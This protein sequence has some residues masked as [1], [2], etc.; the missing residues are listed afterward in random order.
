M[1]PT[2]AARDLI[3][4]RLPIIFPEGTPNRN[5]CTRELAASTVFTMLY[6]GAVEGSGVLLGPVH[7][8]RMTDQQAADWSDEGRQNYRLNLRK[9]NFKVPGNRWYADN[10]REPIR[11][12]TL[13]EGLIAIGAVIE[14][15]TVSTTAGAPRYS[16]RKGL[17]ALFEPS[18]SGEE[19]RAAV[20]DWQEKHLNK[21]A[22]AR[23]S[24]MRLG[25]A[26]KKGV[27]VHFP[28]GETRTLSP[29]PSSEI[30]RAVV[31]VFAKLFLGKPVVLWLSESSNKVAMQD[32]RM[33]ASIGLDIEAQKNLPDLILVDLHPVHPLIVFVEVVAT[34]GAITERRQEALFALTDKG[35]FERSNVA[36]VTAYADRQTQGFKKTISGLAW[37]SF[38]WFLS[39]PDKVFMLSDGIKQLSELNGIISEHQS[40]R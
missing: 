16:I 21:G 9:R 37:G 33:A 24:L 19:F 40:T 30:S 10:T 34:D 18:L 36:F 20:L 8:Y 38:A 12:E 29:G 22:L 1:L 11:D 5:Y 26:D 32:L 31:E 35:G 39:E 25:G 23:I 7:V 17:A 3:A 15:K 13:R 28:N 4:E 6:I 27:L 2:Y 14:D